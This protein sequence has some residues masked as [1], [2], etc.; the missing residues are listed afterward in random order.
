MRNLRLVLVGTEGETNLGMAVRTAVNM[1]VDEIYLVSPRVRLDDEEVIR[2]AAHARR[3]LAWVRVVEGLEEA[4][5]GVCIS[6]C[7]S[8]RHNDWDALRTALELDALPL[9]LARY[10]SAAIVFGRES[11]G[12]TREEIRLCDVLVTI[13]ANPE[14]PVLN[15]AQSVAVVLYEAS[16]ARILGDRLGY[17]AASCRQLD[18]LRAM[19][20]RLVEAYAEEQRR[21][22]AEAALR[23]VI[24]RGA[25]SPGEASQIYRLF[26]ALL[27]RVEA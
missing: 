5:D 21:E 9:L 13:P 11:V 7:T 17:R 4:L 14:Y 10:E 23:H 25:P 2:Y 20:R 8:A 1:G 26:K 6:V 3:W 12:L 18:S 24:F 19:I 27:R 16:K 15:L 22:G